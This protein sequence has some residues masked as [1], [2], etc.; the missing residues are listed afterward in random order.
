MRLSE[1]KGKRKLQKQKRRRTQKRGG[2]MRREKIIVKLSKQHTNPNIGSTIQVL[3]EPRE[4]VTDL[5][6][7]LSSYIDP[8]EEEIVSIK[9]GR[10]KPPYH[11]KVFEFVY[12]DEETPESVYPMKK[13]TP[14][15]KKT[16]CSNEKKRTHLVEENKENPPAID[17]EEIE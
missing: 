16:A 13:L 8:L 10:I 2:R 5:G 9:L 12:N 1:K 7:F 4:M 15:E 14:C 6:G 3:K 11:T 17:I